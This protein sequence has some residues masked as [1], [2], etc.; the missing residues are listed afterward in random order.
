LLIFSAR[1][2]DSSVEDGKLSWA[3]APDDEERGIGRDW[4]VEAGEG[5]DQVKAAP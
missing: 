2:F 1:I 3:A 5:G 4:L